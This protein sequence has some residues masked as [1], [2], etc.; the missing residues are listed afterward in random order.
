MISENLSAIKKRIMEAA[1]KRGRDPGHIKLVAITKERPVEQ[2]K[3]VVAAGV[4]DI[5]E[6]KVQEAVAK[7]SE[8]GL[9]DPTTQRLL[10]WHLVGHL[11]TNKAKDAV[12]IFDLIHSVDSLKLAKEL[13]RQAARINKVQD[14]LVEVDVSAE[15]T[16]FGIAPEKLESLVKD[17]ISLR[18]IRLLGLMTIAPV[19]KDK[20][21]AR[22][23]FAKLRQ[24]QGELNN[25]MLTA[26]I[27]H[28][29]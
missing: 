7:Y 16:K 21:D 12:R 8:L 29:V 27:F 18:N 25:S 15:G 5:G 20:E 2:I 3:E 9:D 23:Y 10:K 22:P 4:F 19:A 28:W 13:D 17:M 24:L 6:N 14:I 1:Q 26:Y 11:Q